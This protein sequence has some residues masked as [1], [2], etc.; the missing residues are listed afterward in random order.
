MMFKVHGNVFLYLDTIVQ[1]FPRETDHSFCL[2]G[3]RSVSTINPPRTRTT[4]RRQGTGTTMRGR[5]YI[6][7]SLPDTMWCESAR[8]HKRSTRNNWETS[9]WFTVVVCLIGI[10]SLKT[11]TSRQGRYTRVKHNHPATATAC[12]IMS[13]LGW[14]LHVAWY[15][16]GWGHLINFI[17]T[18][19][20]YYY[21]CCLHSWKTRM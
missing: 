6:S 17:A 19:K 2:L 1:P 7:L 18:T 9:C 8:F 15:S 12:F 11:H 21:Y 4:A 20:T 5:H 16:L 10:V 3:M 13:C 14:F